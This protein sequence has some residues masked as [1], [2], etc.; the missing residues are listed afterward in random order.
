LHRQYNRG[1]IFSWSDLARSFFIIFENIRKS[2]NFHAK[3]RIIK[4]KLW[5]LQLRKLFVRNSINLK[6]KMDCKPCSNCFISHQQ[7]SIIWNWLIF[8]KIIYILAILI[9]E[10]II[11]C[12]FPIFI[13]KER[14]FPRSIKIRG[15]LGYLLRNL[16]MVFIDLNQRI[17]L[18]KKVLKTYL[19]DVSVFCRTV[20]AFKISSLSLYF[21]I[22]VENLHL[23]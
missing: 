4:S 21:V 9:D 19:C 2:G 7:L 8:A 23:F 10:I 18:T 15:S 11:A 17:F 3:K 5:P 22:F 20:C 16:F 6:F 13:W 12:I 1:I 14:F